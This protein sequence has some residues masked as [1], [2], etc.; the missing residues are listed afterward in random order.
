MLDPSGLRQFGPATALSIQLVV[1]VMI[2]LWAGGELDKRFQT[3][4]WLL[5]L[6][7]FAGFVAGLAVMIRGFARLQENDDGPPTDSA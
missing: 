1:F 6:F 4:P 7:T 5:L 2:G 3:A